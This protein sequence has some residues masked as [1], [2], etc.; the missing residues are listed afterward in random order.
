VR[1]VLEEIPYASITDVVQSIRSEHLDRLMS[2]II[3]FR[4]NTLSI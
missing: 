3:D 1:Q 2:F 4:I